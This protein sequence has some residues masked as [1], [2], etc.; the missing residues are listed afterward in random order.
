MNS[1]NFAFIW[2]LFFGLGV[3]STLAQTTKKLPSNLVVKKNDRN[4]WVELQELLNVEGATIISFWAT[5]C[6]PCL[7]ELNA[8]NEEYASWQN[9]TK[10]KLIAISIDDSRS[11]E[12]VKAFAKTSGWEF[13]TYIDLNGEVNRAMGVNSIIPYTFIL[14]KEGNIVYTH[15]SYM[16]GDES[17]YLEIIT[18]IANNEIIKH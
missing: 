3:G 14:D 18:K 12:R 17:K 2:L 7:M 16:P 9:D 8:I 1:K 10:V 6:K 5:W 15:T 4:E 11:S 13:D